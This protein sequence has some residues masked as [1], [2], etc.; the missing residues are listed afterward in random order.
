M[1]AAILAP[2]VDYFMT[3]RG[4]VK[5]K[6]ESPEDKARRERCERIAIEKA[7]AKR[8]RKTAKRRKDNE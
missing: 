2:S 1:E 3:G 8:E 4:E 7:K 6:K 5:E